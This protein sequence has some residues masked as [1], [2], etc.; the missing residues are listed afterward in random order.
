MSLVR[1][2]RWVQNPWETSLA[3]GKVW[4]HLEILAC[5]AYEKKSPA[6][7]AGAILVPF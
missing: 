3:T 5:G 1:V 4:T 7:D 6:G 2:P